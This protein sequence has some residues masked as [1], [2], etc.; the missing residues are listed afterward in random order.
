M[1]KLQCPTCGALV[2][3]PEGWAKTA[4]SA[5]VP[6]PSVPGMATQVRCPQCQS[7]F[8]QLQGGQPGTWRGLL[9]VAILLGVLLA[10]AALLPG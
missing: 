1:A 4:L 10:I 7:V 6:A 9:P 2:P 5:L 8:T 3:S